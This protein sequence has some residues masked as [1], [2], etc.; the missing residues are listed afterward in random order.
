[1][2]SAIVCRRDKGVSEVK[3]QLRGAVIVIALVALV[4]CAKRVAPQQE[5]AADVQSN[6][7]N[8]VH[9]SPTAGQN[10]HVSM[11]PATANSTGAAAGATAGYSTD[12][13]TAPATTSYQASP[14]DNDVVVQ[15]LP[16][17]KKPKPK[18]RPL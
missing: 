18:K 8:D 3:T 5:S 17:S 6:V 2:E 15:P 12:T 14:T 4:G 16:P 9:S 11:S 10:G 1:M 13:S 7:G